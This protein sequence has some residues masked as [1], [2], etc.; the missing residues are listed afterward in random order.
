M[1]GFE[2]CESVFNR[3]KKEKT[4]AGRFSA[5]HFTG[6]QRSSESQELDNVCRL[7]GLE[8]PASG[9]TKVDSD[10]LPLRRILESAT[11]N[12]GILRLLRAISSKVG[13]G[14]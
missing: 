4:I 8:N 13:G 10:L 3:L 14:A 12:P 11:F 7:P 9:L 2:D 6:I 5:R 1:S